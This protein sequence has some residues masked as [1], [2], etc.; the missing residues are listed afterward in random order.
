MMGKSISKRIVTI[1]DCCYSGR[2]KVAKG[3]EKAVA[4]T[5]SEAILETFENR[6]RSDYNLGEGKD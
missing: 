1:L 4:K 2:A 5:A 6:K 3:N